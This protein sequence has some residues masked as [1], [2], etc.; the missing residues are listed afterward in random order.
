L[1]GEGLGVRGSPEVRKSPI[2]ILCGLRA[3]KGESEVI[4]LN[5]ELSPFGRV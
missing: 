5:R 4:F 2:E 3:A 1:G